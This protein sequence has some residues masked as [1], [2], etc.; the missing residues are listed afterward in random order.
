MKKFL[1]GL[2]II[3]VVFISYIL[4]KT[5]TFTS[6]QMEVQAVEPIVIN[7]AVLDRF[8]TALRIKT[9]SFENKADF[10]STQFEAFNVFLK[11]S[12][13]LV[14]SLLEHQVFNQY[15]HLFK[16]T[17][18]DNSLKPVILM[19]HIDV[20]PIASPGKW[21]VD[22]FGG[23]IKDD[24]IWGRGTIDDKFSVISILEAVELLLSEDFQ[25]KRTTYLAFGHDE[26]VGGDLGAVA[27]VAYLKSQGVSAEYV[28]D[29]GYAITQQLIPGVED[30]VAFIG[31]AEKG[32]TTIEL[33]VDMD[34]GHSSQPASET[35]IDVLA[36][37]VVKVKGNPLEA[38]LSAPMMEFI[39]QIG[40]EM[41][42]VNKMAFANTGIFKPLIVS[43]Y[44]SSGGTG[45][46]LIRTTT[47]P[48]IF[49]AGIKENIIPTSARA[50]I[51]FRIIPG[52][53]A[54][55][56]LSHV[57]SVVNDERVKTNFFGF[58]SNPSPVSPTDSEGYDLINKSMKQVFDGLLTAP[59]L[60]I[61]ATDSRHF[62]E[63]S[64]N[65]Y[66]FVPYHIN[67]SNIKTFHGIDERIP[68]EDYKNAIR[69]YRQLILNGN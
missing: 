28:L 1:V 66:R 40:P 63:I 11:E 15:S 48:T 55:D 58:N 7:D 30:D 21:S 27:I 46:A 53:N 56:V 4:F 9:I 16:W 38:T 60:V 2:L 47:S 22:P 35:A 61:A 45:N 62:T 50:L 24:V 43:T 57:N 32:S 14:D 41:G 20:V 8:Q 10:D 31:I 26:E 13:P 34:G 68:V 44:E 29:E 67:Q 51:N 17:G 65:I 5:F 59:N 19:G 54:D 49:Q 23:I 69:F 37:A 42:F 3:I 52:Q 18:S 36:N 39:N 12:F 25:P 33:T 6:N 64:P